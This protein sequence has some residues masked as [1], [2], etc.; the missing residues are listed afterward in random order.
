MLG[1]CVGLQ[2]LTDSGYEDGHS[3]GL[4]W[5]EGVSLPFGLVAGDNPV[6]HT[7]WNNLTVHHHHGAVPTSFHSVGGYYYFNHGHIVH[8]ADTTVVW[9]STSYATAF[10][11]FCGRENVIGVQ[12]HPEKSGH[13]GL[14]FLHQFLQWDGRP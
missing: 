7:G 9:G 12:F 2:I 1:I 3:T 4:G 5:V 13:A 6:P 14:H 11:S 10:A 8:V